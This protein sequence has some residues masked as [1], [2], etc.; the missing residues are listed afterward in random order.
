MTLILRFSK[1]G[2]NM[3]TS[4][5]RNSLPMNSGLKCRVDI[6]HATLKMKYIS[7][8]KTKKKKVCN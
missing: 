4:L 1:N 7:G 5:P 3:H 6:D 8:K 2:M